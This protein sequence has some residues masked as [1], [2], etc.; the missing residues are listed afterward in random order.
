MTQFIDPNVAYNF[1]KFYGLSPVVLGQSQIGLTLSLRD[2]VNKN[3]NINFLFPADFSTPNYSV[4]SPT[5]LAK[6]NTNIENQNPYAG[7]QIF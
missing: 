3:R 6:V 4:S 1:Q 5:I 7:G 2:R